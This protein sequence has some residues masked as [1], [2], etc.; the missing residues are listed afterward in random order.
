MSSNG[1]WAPDQGSRPNQRVRRTS[2]QAANKMSQDGVSSSQPPELEEESS[3]AKTGKSGM[4]MSWDDV[5]PRRT[6][7]KPR[8]A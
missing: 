4:L 2:M 3:Q 8:F 5:T 6:T 7:G 1:W